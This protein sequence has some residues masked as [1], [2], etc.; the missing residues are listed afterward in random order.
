MYDP[1]TWETFPTGT[2]INPKNG[3]QLIK[4]K[5]DNEASI[6][7]RIEE[8]TEKTLKIVDEQKKEGKVIEIDADWTPEAVHQEI[9][10]KLN[11]IA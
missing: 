3:N 1:K 11:E 2:E 10:T 4:R 6:L 9:I 8:Y 5:D 7:K